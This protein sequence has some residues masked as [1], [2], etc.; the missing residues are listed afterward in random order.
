M[1]L[2]NWIWITR[3]QQRTFSTWH[4]SSFVPKRRELDKGHLIALCSSCHKRLR[5]RTQTKTLK[6]LQLSAE[7]WSMLE[8]RKDFFYYYTLSSR[9]PSSFVLLLLRPFRN[10]V[11]YRQ[12][13]I[14]DPRVHI[15]STFNSYFSSVFHQFN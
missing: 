8:N 2:R 4:L 15:L 11:V 13:L 5:F 6:F 12:D 7:N 9:N 14:C 1:N 3:N 10:G